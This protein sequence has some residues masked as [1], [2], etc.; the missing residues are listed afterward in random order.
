VV[1][2]DSSA[3]LP[4]RGKL[5]HFFEYLKKVTAPKL[6][7]IFF[8]VSSLQKLPGNIGPISNMLIAFYSL[9]NAMAH[10]FL[11]RRINRILPFTFI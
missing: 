3:A 1:S 7:N 11:R 5:L 2:D 6:F 9:R 10:I 8:G 4:A